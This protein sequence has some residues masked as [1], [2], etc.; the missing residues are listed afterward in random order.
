MYK[1]KNMILTAMAVLATGFGLASC[2]QDRALAPDTPS[3]VEVTVKGLLLVEQEDGS[4]VEVDPSFLRA[5]DDTYGQWSGLGTYPSNTKVTVSFASKSPWYIYSFF[6]KSVGEGSGLTNNR[7]TDFK[8]ASLAVTRDVTYVAKVRK[9]GNKSTTASVSKKSVTIGSG[10]GSDN[11]TIKITEETPILDKD[12]KKV[13]DIT[14]RG[15]T[16]KSLKVTEKPVWVVANATNGT[17]TIQADKNLQPDRTTNKSRDGKVTIVADGQTV[18]VA[19]HQDSRFD[20]PNNE[21][22]SNEWMF[23]NGDGKPGSHHSYNFDAVGESYDIKNKYRNFGTNPIDVLTAVYL[24]GELTDKS[25]WLTQSATWSY[26]KPAKDWVSNKLNVYTAQ[27]NE[28]G[29]DRDTSTAIITLRLTSS[30]LELCKTRFDFTQN[31]SGFVVD[32]EIQ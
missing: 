20:V 25:Q 13:D 14:N 6:D 17:V 21:V 11:V 12:G 1:I 4:Y 15:L 23:K 26:G 3:E 24:N 10:G 32:G 28:T 29:K 19:V 9:L 18:T 22:R 7:T 31:T 16:P 8:S 2:Q 30:S 5:T 27:K